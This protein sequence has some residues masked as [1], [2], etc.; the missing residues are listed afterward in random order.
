ML[1]TLTIQQQDLVEIFKGQTVSKVK[2]SISTFPMVFS[3]ASMGKA[4][5]KQ[6]SKLR[7]NPKHDQSTDS[8]STMRS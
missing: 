4:S 2:Q 5:L 7:K 6:K 1:E 8:L 3:A